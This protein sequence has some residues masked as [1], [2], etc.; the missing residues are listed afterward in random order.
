MFASHVTAGLAQG[1]L[2]SGS[3]NV[4]ALRP[5]EHEGQMYQYC[6]QSK[7]LIPTRNASMLRIDDWRDID[8][9]VIEVTKQR[10]VG[11]ADLMAKGLTYNL[12]SIGVTTSEWDK[13]SDM[14]AADINMSGDVTPGSEDTVTFSPTGVPVP[15]IYKDFRLNLRR[16]EASRRNGQGLDVVQVDVAT[17]LV[18]EKS[19][20]MLFAGSLTFGDYTIYGYRTHPSVNNVDMAEKWDDAGCSGVDIVDDVTDMIQALRSDGFHGPYCMYIP[21]DYQ[22]K[23]DEDYNPSVG[24]QRTIRERLLK[25]DGLTEIKVADRLADDNVIMVQLTRDVVDLAIAQ[26][27]TPVQWSPNGGMTEHFRVMAVWVPRVK[28]DYDGHCGVARLYEID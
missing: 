23:L 20:D 25:L 11:F 7:K 16:L 10:L 15:V 5:V 1:L 18:A 22:T 13:M 24:D 12:G 19:E 4:H 28:S 27:I 2:G 26:D 6:T 8:R 17:R 21:K 9:T 3:F 14:T